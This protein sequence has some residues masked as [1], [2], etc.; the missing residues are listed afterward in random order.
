[1][2]YSNLFTPFHI[3]MLSDWL[4]VSSELFVHFEFPHSGGSGFSNTITS[5][6]ELKVLLSQQ[7]HPEIEIF[8]FRSKPQSDEEL[9]ERVDLQ[10]VYRNPEIVLYIAVN[11][12]RNYY[13]EYQEEPI[14][15]KE[16]VAS[17]FQQ[18]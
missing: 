12:N 18:S 6:A 13:E 3:A 15:Y 17:W 1:M 2:N 9:N 11:K 7:S 14:K 5:L 4:N 8:I 16:T 10:W